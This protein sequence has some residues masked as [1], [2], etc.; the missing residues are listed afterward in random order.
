MPPSLLHSKLYNELGFTSMTVYLLHDFGV[1]IKN[2]IPLH[3]STGLPSCIFLSS[4]Q[5]MPKKKK[6]KLNAQ[7]P[8]YN[9][10]AGSCIQIH[11]KCVNQDIHIAFPTRTIEDCQYFYHVHVN[12][13]SLRS[14][15]LTEIKPPTP[16]VSP[17]VR[18][19][20]FIFPKF[21][22]GSSQQSCQFPP[23]T[24][25][26]SKVRPVPEGNLTANIYPVPASSYTNMKEETFDNSLVS[27]VLCKNDYIESR[28]GKT[29]IKVNKQTPK[30]AAAISS[31]LWLESKLYINEI[32]CRKD[33][34]HLMLKVTT[35]LTG[36]N[37]AAF[38]ARLFGPKKTT[39][40]RAHHAGS[41]EKHTFVCD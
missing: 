13:S 27:Q 4:S 20:Y 25:L 17:A 11:K 31:S 28:T 29:L 8:T 33:A 26:E 2:S 14:Q 18:T 3:F 22:A 34:S 38:S 40:Q 15:C 16:A 23:P 12:C 1:R 5:Q 30:S 32:L 6:K 7:L 21:K 19:K 10:A 24:K 41:R 37:M 35:A 39:H 9:Q 36:N